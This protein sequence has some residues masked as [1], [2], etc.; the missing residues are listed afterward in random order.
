[1]KT[2]VFCTFG[3]FGLAVLFSIRFSSVAQGRENFGRTR[4]EA[5]VAGIVGGD[6]NK[7]PPASP[8]KAGNSV[9]PVVVD[10]SQTV[11]QMIKAGKYDW[12]ELEINSGDFPVN[13]RGISKVDVVLLPIHRRRMESE[14]ILRELDKRNLRPAGLPELLAFGAT[15]P[16]KQQEVPP[17]VALGPVSQD[18]K[19]L[20]GAA[21]LGGGMRGRGLAGPGCWGPACHEGYQF[22][23]VV[24]K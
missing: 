9:F 8:V 18:W 7:N 10:C 2:I 1:M 22:A 17:I 3:A 13:C 23:A 20:R 5:R 24:R 19:T 15:Y 6:E 4:N 12:R 11:E 21:Y 14:E 16:D